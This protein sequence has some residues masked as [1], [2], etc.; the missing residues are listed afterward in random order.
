MCFR[1]QVSTSGWSLVHRS[2]TGCSVPLCDRE[3][4]IMRRPWPNTDCC[5]MKRSVY[6]IIYKWMNEYGA[7]VE[8]YWQG[9]TEVRGVKHYRLILKLIV[10]YLTHK[11]QQSAPIISQ[12][13]PVYILPSCFFK[14]LFN[15][16]SHLRLG[17]PISLFPYRC[18]RWISLLLFPCVSLP[19]LIVSFWRP[20]LLHLS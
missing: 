17:P 13:N 4:W 5:A 14:I 20:L 15:I 1:V 19:V 10:H 11:S 8:W 9:K 7:M 2:P 3:A 18:L 16:S 12:R 6:I